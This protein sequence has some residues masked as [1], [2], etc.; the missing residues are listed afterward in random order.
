MNQYIYFSSKGE[1]NN[2]DTANSDFSV[3][4]S[5]PIVIPPYAEIRCVNCR[6]NPNN[7]TFAVQE[8]VN[9]RLAFSVGKFWI[10]EQDG[11]DEDAYN[12][13][14]PL[15]SVKLDEGI[16]DLQSGTDP[17]FYLNAQIESKINEQITNNPTLRNGVT[18]EVDGNKILTIK[19]STMGA[20]GYYTTPDGVNLPDTLIDKLKRINSRTT[21]IPA[22]LYGNKPEYGGRRVELAP[23]RMQATAPVTNMIPPNQVGEYDVTCDTLVNTFVVG[24]IVNIV[25]KPSIQAK[26]TAVNANL[27]TK[28]QIFNTDDSW[29]TNINPANVNIQKGAN[30]CRITQFTTSGP[31]W[32][33]VTLYNDPVDFGDATIL[34][35]CGYFMSP[36]I[37]WNSLGDWEADDDNEYKLASIFSINLEKYE[38]QSSVTTW[39]QTYSCFFDSIRGMD[40]GVNTAGL[41]AGPFSGAVAPHEY[42]DATD[43]PVPF[44][45][46]DDGGGDFT[47]DVDD[48]DLH[49]LEDYLFRVQVEFI[50]DIGTLRIYNKSKDTSSDQW[51]WGNLI[52][53][54]T[55]ATP[56][57]IAIDPD[58]GYLCIETYV[59]PN[60]ETN[61]MVC[62]IVVKT[63]NGGDEWEI[64]Q[65]IRGIFPNYLGF[66][67]LCDKG[68][69]VS[70]VGK[71]ANIRFSYCSNAPNSSLYDNSNNYRQPDDIYWAGAYNP[72]DEANGF[73][74]GAFRS[75]DYIT[76]KSANLPSNLPAFIFGDEVIGETD[77][78]V[79]TQDNPNGN[80]VVEWTGLGDERL[81]DSGANAGVI[82]G[83]D[84]QGWQYVK[85]N[86]FTTGIAFSGAVNLNARDFPQ[87]YLDL[88]D[89]AVKNHT[90]VVDGTGRPNHFIC[91]L[92]LNSGAGTNNL[93][94]SQNDTLLY[95]DLGNAM[96]ERITNLRIRICD[97]EGTPSTNLQNYTLGC[98]EVRENP[99]MKQMKMQRALQRQEEE[100]L[101]YQSG[102]NPNRGNRFQ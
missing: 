3:N 76:T 2:A 39:R 99:Q 54:A 93:H 45:E 69:L 35:R 30:T 25:G 14:F 92:D 47:T 36:P 90:G 26:V 40:C 49:L 86:S 53:E 81:R 87:H 28:I 19:V 44:I 62:Q 80:T 21:S 67:K 64:K 77:K 51:D 55:N 71:P 20:N 72:I 74:N 46:P 15:F 23:L 65:S 41:G 95:N 82:L 52:D 100:A 33:G 29:K 1:H 102:V 8:G 85:A 17:R 56:E 16:Y 9:D 58:D 11:E 66:H 12:N 78:L 13:A 75:A 84:E 48:N 31:D 50:G 7:N 43:F 96:E 24:D 32:R 89:L 101:S 37:N 91:P 5:N 68:A 27:P 22:L 60:V 38:E 88:P 73:V 6:V 70:K 61:A 97:L 57:E 4:F 98:I 59:A 10:L 18:V 94:S 79:I 83:L 63:K 34:Q 42:L